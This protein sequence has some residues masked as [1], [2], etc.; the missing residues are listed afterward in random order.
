MNALIVFSA[1]SLSIPLREVAKLYEKIYGEKV[2]IE[3]SGSVQAMRKILELGRCPDVLLVADYKLIPTMLKES[4]VVGFATNTMTIAY[5]KGQYSKDLQED[6]IGFLM[7][8][9]FAISNP[10]SWA[11]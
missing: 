11:Y 10:N 6:W 9:T 1:G 5:T 7:T 2:Y 3:F 4:W 8:H